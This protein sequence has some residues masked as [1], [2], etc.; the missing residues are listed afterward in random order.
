M[1]NDVSKLE[2]NCV[3]ILS[4][5]ALGEL[6]LTLPLILE[7]RRI[8]PRATITLVCNRPP[9]T[10]L[11]RELGIAENVVLIPARSW[12]SPIA[13][14][15][16]LRLMHAIG[17]DILLQPFTSHGTLGNILA[18]ASGAKIRCGYFSGH[19]QKA[20]TH[21]IPADPDIHRITSNLNLLRRLGHSDVSVPRGRYLPDMERRSQLYPGGEVGDKYGRYAVISIGTNP[22]LAF[23]KWSPDNW[24]GLCKLLLRDG[25]T[26][27]FV[28]DDSL[29]GEVD[30]V[31]S[32]ADCSG[33][34][35]AGKTNFPDLAA[36]IRSSDVVV[37]CDGMVLH[38]A[39][40]MNKASVGIF[41]PTA[42]HLIGPW[43]DIHENVYLSLPCSPCYGGRSAGQGGCA[44]RECL[45]N[46]SVSMVYRNVTTILGRQS[47]TDTACVH[48]ATQSRLPAR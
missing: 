20:L 5:S 35:L 1:N 25:L 10:E 47:H 17:A 41:G 38:L 15:K 4:N 14:W 18:A 27:V 30:E 12:R 28:G 19:F 40:A 24:A 16:S 48:S 37:G 21:R 7:S 29:C 36:L 32:I 34:N 31:L 33:I 23:K 11:A 22:I 39:A 45:N 26:P 13:L 46:I 8:Y 9:V 6:L 43:G 3:T 42:P 2:V 44:A